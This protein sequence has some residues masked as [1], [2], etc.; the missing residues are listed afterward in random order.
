MGWKQLPKLPYNIEKE[1]T[2]A[3]FSHSSKIDYVMFLLYLMSS[4]DLYKYV[5]VL[6]K[7]QMFDYPL[8]SWIIRK[9]GGIKSSRIEEH[10]SQCSS[11][12]NF[13]NNKDKFIF[14]I[15]PKGTTKYKS[16]H[17]NMKS[18]YKYIAN[19]TNSKIIVCGVDYYTKE[20]KFSHEV[21]MRD[22]IHEMNNDIISR[23]MNINPFDID[24]EVSLFRIRIHYHNIVSIKNIIISTLLLS[25]PI[26][27]F[28]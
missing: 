5:Y 4:P 17:D 16:T 8:L 13:L 18:G 7:P 15:S 19:E 25:I 22:S 9:C 28:M 1:R 14:L 26:Y 20:I 3:I 12:I 27:T 6:I 23:M 24:R 11:I 21:K 2:V 10:G